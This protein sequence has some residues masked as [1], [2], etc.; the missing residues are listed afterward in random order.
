MPSIGIYDRLEDEA[1]GSRGKF[2]PI[3]GVLLGVAEENENDFLR[4]K[5]GVAYEVIGESIS[6]SGC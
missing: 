1:A 4:T 3:P 5:P 2:S 6:F